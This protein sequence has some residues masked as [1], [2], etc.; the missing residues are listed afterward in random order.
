MDE[1]TSE[2]PRAG[3]APVV[4]AAVGT[5]VGAGVAAAA[6]AVLVGGT[7][8]W[9]GHERSSAPGSF[10][11]VEAAFTA[12][13]L[14]VCSSSAA[15]DPLAPGALA[16]RS[17]VVGAS[18]GGDGGSGSGTGDTATVVVDEFATPAERDAAARRFEAL[19][20]PRASGV[21]LTLGD[22]TVSV[23]GS[24]DTAVTRALTGA[25]RAAGGR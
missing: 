13:G 22:T 2:R 15:A 24:G 14:T 19:G 10:P 12:A 9:A 25:L 17:Y 3:R 1:Q 21:V 23:Q 6:L 16:S 18:C 11:Q 8:W 20:R 5:A 4:G 7:A